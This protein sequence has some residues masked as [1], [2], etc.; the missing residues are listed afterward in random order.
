[1]RWPQIVII[2]LM[3][4]STGMALV[5]HGEPRN[6]K[7][8]FWVELISNLIMAGLLWFGGFWG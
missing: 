3:A 7:Y 6:A 2:V 4:M 8:N 5:K 1:M